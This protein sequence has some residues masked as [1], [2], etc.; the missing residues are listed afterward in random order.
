[1]VPIVTG[2]LVYVPKCLEMYINQIGFNKTETEKSVQ[3]L[4]NRSVSGTVKICKTF[5]K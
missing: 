4:Q 3:K 1:M 5:L 2:A